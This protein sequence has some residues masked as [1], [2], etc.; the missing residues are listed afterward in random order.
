VLFVVACN[1]GRS[2]FL[3]KENLNFSAWL[4]NDES[5][6]VAR[7][8]RLIEAVTSLNMKTAEDLQVSCNND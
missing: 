4:R 8:S 7:L 6:I 3:Y 5:P 1:R 2:R